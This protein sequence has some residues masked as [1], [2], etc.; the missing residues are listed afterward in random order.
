M[1]SSSSAKRSRVDENQ[2]KAI[3][4]VKQE[5]FV[6]CCSHPSCLRNEGSNRITKGD[7]GEGCRSQHADKRWCIC[8]LHPCDGSSVIDNGSQDT[9]LLSVHHADIDIRRRNLEK[10]GQF[11]AVI[12]REAKAVASE[13][14]AGQRVKELE[15]L[16][17]QEK[18]TCNRC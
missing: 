7:Y 11:D 10:L 13:T 1:D 8:L 2:V 12:D 3:A 4:D 6:Y 16:L 14:T 5:A 9:H 18:K 15:S 17:E